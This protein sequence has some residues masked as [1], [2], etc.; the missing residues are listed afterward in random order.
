MVGW[1]MKPT[2][3]RDLVIDALMMALWRRKPIPGRDR[4][5]RP[6]LTVRQR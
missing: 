2:M 1:S 5:L 4:S 3:A 6:R